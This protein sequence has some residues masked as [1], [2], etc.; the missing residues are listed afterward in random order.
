MSKVVGFG[1]LLVH[2]SP[3]GY[4]RFPQASSFEVGYTGAEAN[5]LVFLAING[6]QTEF[7]T[8]LPENAIAECALMHLKKYGVGVR[9]VVFGGDRIGTYFLEK[10]ASQRPS[11]LVYDRKFTSFATSQLDDFDWNTI[12]AGATHFHFTG[13]TPALSPALPKICAR[14]CAEAQKRGIFVSLDLNYRSLLWDLETASL[15]MRA[16]LPDVDLLI[17]GREDSEKLLGVAP[18][19]RDLTGDAVDRDAYAE[20]AVE[21]SRRYGCP[22]VAFTL[23]ESLTASDNGWSGLLYT[24]GNAYCSREYRIHIVDRVGGGDAFTAGLLFA[25]T[26]GY[27]PQHT[28][29]FA[30]AAGCLKHTIE[31]DFN[32]STAAEIEQLAAGESSGRIQR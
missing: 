10:G 17:C 22:E 6:V 23:R 27:D 4:Q 26:Q 28:V 8:R 13:I 24:G 7:V 14:A 31:Q 29:E 18:K 19:L 3:P 15:A 2:L 30:A 25:D 5:V 21:L 9:H 12:F 32:L 11:R 1:D 16:L 20:A